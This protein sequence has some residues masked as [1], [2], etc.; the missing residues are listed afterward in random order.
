M[1]FDRQIAMVLPSRHLDVYGRA[2]ILLFLRRC[3]V[4]MRT[5]R[6]SGPSTQ[7]SIFAR[8]KELTMSYLPFRG[9]FHRALVCVGTLL[10]TVFLSTG[11]ALAVPVDYEFDSGQLAGTFT[12]DATLAQPFTASSITLVGVPFGG[13]E[14][15][16]FGFGTW[17]GAGFSDSV[18]GPTAFSGDFGGTLGTLEL[19]IFIPGGNYSADILGPPGGP[20]SVAGSF[21]PVPEPSSASVLMIGLLALAGYGWQQWRR[22][23]GQIG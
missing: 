9:Q 6:R 7:A 17:S 8:E 22:E 21:S 10:F 18:Q 15:W 1:K 2:S 5:T 19:F 11:V 4:L 12:L 20:Y 16:T 14:P 23:K 13:Q 3:V